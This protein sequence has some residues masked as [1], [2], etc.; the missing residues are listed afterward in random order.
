MVQIVL[1][2]GGMPEADLYFTTT[3]LGIPLHAG[4]FPDAEASEYGSEGHAGLMVC[5]NGRGAFSLTG[6]FTI[7]DLTYSPNGSDWIINS[8]AASFEQHVF[9]DTPALRGMITYELNPVPE[10][11]SM[12]LIASGLAGLAGFRK[13][14]Q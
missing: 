14:K 11:C 6:Q 3:K 10:P 9:G 4:Y 13:L 7:Y 2:M 8:F 1:G 12:V 5:F